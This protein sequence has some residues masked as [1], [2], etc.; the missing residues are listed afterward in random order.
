[1]QLEFSMQF[2]FMMLQKQLVMSWNAVAA[3]LSNCGKREAIQQKSF[4]WSTLNQQREI[5]RWLTWGK[6]SGNLL[7]RGLEILCLGESQRSWKQ[8]KAVGNQ[9]ADNMEH[10]NGTNGAEAVYGRFVCSPWMWDSP[11]WIR[12]KSTYSSV[13][14]TL[15]AHKGGM[16]VVT[17][18]DSQALL[19]KL[20]Y[21]CAQRFCLTFPPDSQSCLRGYAP[22]PPKKKTETVCGAILF[23]PWEA[24]RSE[25]PQDGF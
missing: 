16:K 4:V 17:A 8:W 15:V 18:V 19:S 10:A 13:L 24:P 23:K 5:S 2:L 12:P 20:Y 9:S 6:N 22:P 3:C 1:M 25:M 11:C 14:F 21:L 7:S